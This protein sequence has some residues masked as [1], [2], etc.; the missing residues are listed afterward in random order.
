MNEQNILKERPTNIKGLLRHFNNL[1]VTKKNESKENEKINDII[2]KEKTQF[3]K[4]MIKN[5][6]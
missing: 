6:L 2:I 5:L 4:T 1:L 3:Q